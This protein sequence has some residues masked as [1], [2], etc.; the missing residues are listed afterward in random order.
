M[1]C[2]NC[3]LINPPGAILC[4]CGYDFE[5]RVQTRERPAAKASLSSLLPAA[6]AIV[7]SLAVVGLLRS[8]P[9]S[10]RTAAY[11]VSM[12]GAAL[13]VAI[14]SRW[15]RIPAILV[16][17]CGVLIGLASVGL[18]YTPTLFASAWVTFREDSSRPCT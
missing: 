5:R 18:L 9:P 4:D 3:K 11:M 6:V 16:L 14:P 2:P 12:L 17:F 10:G 7:P 1:D 8:Q 15:V 13:L